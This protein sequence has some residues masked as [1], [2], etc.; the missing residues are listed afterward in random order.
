MRSFGA[1]ITFGI[2]FNAIFGLVPAYISRA[3]GAGG[4]TLVF[5][6]GNIALGVGGMAGNMFGGALKEST[7]SFEPIYV[8]MFGAAVCSGLLSAMLPS[9]RRFRLE[10]RRAEA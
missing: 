9:E 7:G 6:I 3:F 5:T 2:S 10:A 1:A 4:A 8:I